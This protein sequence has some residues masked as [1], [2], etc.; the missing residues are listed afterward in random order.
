MLIDIDADFML[1][2]RLECAEDRQRHAN[3]WISPPDLVAS[4]RSAGLVR[5]DCARLLVQHCEAYDYWRQSGIRNATCIH[6]DAHSDLYGSHL[7]PGKLI[8]TGYQPV[9]GNYLRFALSIGL[10]ADVT[11]VPPDW[12]SLSDFV[13]D[14]LRPYGYENQPNVHLCHLRNLK[15]PSASQILVTVATSPQYTPHWIDNESRMLLRFFEKDMLGTLE[16]TR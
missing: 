15:I 3:L 1:D 13:K 11:I 2:R 7:S 8:S 4:L 6:L 14:E 9:A 16:G 10:V 5:V 12:L